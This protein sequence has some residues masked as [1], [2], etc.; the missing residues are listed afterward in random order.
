MDLRAV[1]KPGIFRARSVRDAQARER[2]GER[3][4]DMRDLGPHPA[5]GR[6]VEIMFADGI[7]ILASTVD[8]EFPDS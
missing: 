5:G 1:G 2:D 6:E 4:L 7:W 8:L 3:F